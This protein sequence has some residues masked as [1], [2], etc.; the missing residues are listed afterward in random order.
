MELKELSDEQLQPILED[1]VIFARM[2]PEDKLRLVAAYQSRGEVVAVTGDGV[3]DAPALRKADI[4]ISMGRYGT[5]VAREAAG[6]ILTNDDFSA[7]I[8]ALQEGRA[9]YDN[10]RKTLTYI[11]SSNVPELLP[12]LFAALFNLP[13]ALSVAQIL[14]IDLGTDLIPGLALGAEKPEPDVML[15]KPRRRDQPIVDGSLLRRAFLWLGPLEAG[16]AFTGFFLV[17]ALGKPPAL[18][19]T[20]FFGGVV[21]S[22]AGNVFACRTETNRGRSLGWLSNMTIWLG[23]GVEIM[24]VVLLLYIPSISRVFDTVPLPTIAWLWLAFYA[25]LVYS[26]DWIR[27]WIVRRRRQ[28][29]ST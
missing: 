20:M 22:Q 17:Y 21:I 19:V 7:L 14:A 18:A 24:L 9:Y 29:E 8:T 15:R 12:F 2:S 13:L 11:F 28:K 26:L 25:P 16:L 10:I 4:G 3:N 27:K 23:V 5:D 6:V 1:E